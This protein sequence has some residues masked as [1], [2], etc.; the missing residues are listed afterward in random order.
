MTK[1]LD[2]GFSEASSGFEFFRLAFPH[3]DHRIPH[4]AKT[5]FLSR[6][7]RSIVA[8]LVGPELDV[9]LRYRRSLAAFMAVPKTAMNEYAPTP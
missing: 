6:V 9:S 5:L 7:P 2:Q 4:C 8:N 3:G 1:T